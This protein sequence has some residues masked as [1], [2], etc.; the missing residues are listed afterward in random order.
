MTD[1]SIKDKI[2]QAAAQQFYA[3]G[4]SAITMDT[5]ADSLG[6]SKKTL[7]TVFSGKY[8]LLVHVIEF[9]KKDLSGSVDAVLAEDQPF[10]EKFRNMLLTIG[11]KLSEIS[12]EF[13]ADLQDNLPEVWESLKHYKMEAA[14]LR[15]NKLVQQGVREGYLSKEINTDVVVAMYAACIQQLMDERF[16]VQLPD[17]I[18]KGLPKHPA[19]IFDSIIQILFNGIEN[20][21]NKMQS[22]ALNLHEIERN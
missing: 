10:T 19:P 21:H 5:I 9:F 13:V 8:D 2:V 17:S 6:M 1:I 15:F 16:L 14:Y 12:Q 7:Y 20:Q 3:N 4:Y 22:F 18:R 11:N